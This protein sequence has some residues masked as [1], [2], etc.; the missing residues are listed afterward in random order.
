MELTGKPANQSLTVAFYARF[1]S[2]LNGGLA[3]DRLV[4]ESGPMP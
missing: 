2:L 3:V 1:P 4:F